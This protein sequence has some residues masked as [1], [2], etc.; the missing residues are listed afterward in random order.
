[1]STLEDLIADLRA[2]ADN[3]NIA[4]WIRITLRS[5]SVVCQQ[6]QLAKLQIQQNTD[7]I[8]RE[9]DRLSFMRS[10][11]E[12]HRNQEE[13]ARRENERLSLLKSHEEFMQNHDEYMRNGGGEGSDNVVEKQ[14]KL[15][16]S[17]DE[18]FAENRI[19][20]FT[21]NAEEIT[22]FQTERIGKEYLTERNTL[23]LSDNNNARS[24]NNVFNE[25]IFAKS[26]RSNSI[27][28][29][30]STDS[31]VRS[32]SFTRSFTQEYARQESYVRYP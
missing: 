3:P 21:G 2:Q 9:N 10:Q 8:R 28:A 6:L 5:S 19:E 14:D 13:Y 30:P 25:D 11:E 29:D 18:G 7:E 12:F 1:M 16:I 32:D 31:F 24:Q 15:S 17:G 4:P 20:T 23:L 26:S 22:S 27:S